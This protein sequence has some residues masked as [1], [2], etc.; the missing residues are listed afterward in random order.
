V[1]LPDKAFGGTTIHNR[2]ICKATEL[3]E[4]THPDSRVF[5]RH[6]VLTGD[7]P[8]RRM[9]LQEEKLRLKEIV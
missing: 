1:F 3:Q 5:K 8:D 6:P 9:V 2:L 4:D 7:V